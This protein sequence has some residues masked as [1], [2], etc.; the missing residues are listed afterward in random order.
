MS[1]VRVIAID[2]DGDPVAGVRVV[3][4]SGT[5]FVDGPEIY[6]TDSDGVANSSVKTNR[7]SYLGSIAAGNFSLFLEHPN[8]PIFSGY[9]RGAVGVV[10]IS[11]VVATTTKLTVRVRLTSSDATPR[12]GETVV[13]TASQCVLAANAGQAVLATASDGSAAGTLLCPHP[14]A[15]PIAVEAFAAGTDSDLQLEVIP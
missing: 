4:N 6:L 9:P 7:G 11:S 10:R 8:G 12:A 15:G 2:G 13:V 14:K 1:A 5:V 3:I